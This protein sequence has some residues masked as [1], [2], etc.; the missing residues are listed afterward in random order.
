MKLPSIPGGEKEFTFPPFHVAGV[1]S[2]DD[3]L[4]PCLKIQSPLIQFR[5]IIEEKYIPKLGEGHR[6]FICSPQRH[7]TD[8]PSPR[9]RDELGPANIIKY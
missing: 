2:E 7:G 6:I 8:D 9:V 4:V 3:F 1:S 5:V